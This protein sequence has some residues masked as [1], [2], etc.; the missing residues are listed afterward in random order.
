MPVPKEHAAD[1]GLRLVAGE[2]THLERLRLALDHAPDMLFVI[3]HAEMRF[4]DVNQ[5]ACDLLGYTRSELLA[6]SPQDILPHTRAELEQAYAALIGDPSRSSGLTSHYRCKDGSRV[7]FESKR[8]A[9]RGADGRWLIVVASRDIRPMLAAT[10]ALRESE[11]ALRRGQAMARLAHAVTD[12]DGALLRASDNLAHLLGMDPQ[13]L[14]RTGREWYG[15]VHPDDH[16][17]F[18]EAAITAARSAAHAEIKYRL[19]CGDGTWMHVRHLIEPLEPLAADGGRQWFNTL[20]DITEQVRAEERI[21]RLTRVY[22]VLSG[23]NGLIVR[24]TSRDELFEAACRVAVE[25]GGF[26]MAWIGLVDRDAGLVRPMA[27]A[28][29]VGD[30]FATAPLAILE[31][32]PGGYGLAG[33]AV[34]ERK[35]IVSNDV[36]GDSQ[37]LMKA[38]LAARGID[39]VAIV[40]LIRGEE[41]VGILAL[42][43]AEI[44]FFDEEELRL[45]VELA[46]DIAFGLEHIEKSEKLDY[47]AYYDV[48][49]GLAN[50]TLFLER[51]E[52]QVAAARSSYRKLAIFLMDIERFKPIN[53]ALGRQAGDAL[54]TQ[55][56]ERMRQTGVDPARFGKPAA[57]QFAVLGL[58]VKSE[59]ALARMVESRL[60]ELF[61]RPFRI[62]GQELRVSV[63]VGIAV[64]PNDGGD[65]ETLF[66]NAEAALKKAKA[67]GERYLFHTAELTGQVAERLSLE[68]KLRQALEREEFVLHYQPKIDLETRRIAGVEAL[69]RWQSPELGLVAPGR[70]I[71]VLEETG[72]IQPVGHWALL[73]ASSDYRAWV[74]QGL[75]AP[76]IAVNVSPLQLRQ[77]DFVQRIDEATA[78]NGRRAGIDLEITESLMMANVADNID[79]LNAVRRLGINIAIDD[80][81]TGYSSL[82]YLA[83]L[84]VQSLKIDRSFI[85][86]MHFDSSAMTLVSTIISLAHSMRLKVIAEGVETED[87]AKYLRLLRCDEMQGYLISRPL[88]PAAL[89]DFL[90]RDATGEAGASPSG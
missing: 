12:Q 21:A 20:Q 79:K 49:T 53:D 70:F 6:K 27:S 19:R 54:L 2:R 48:L 16:A 90:R 68:N 24:A 84:P 40:P 82:G 59:E 30:F 38:E 72:L 11:A 15:L 61:E 71:P 87:Q 35:P 69:I 25:Q 66:R 75:S 8:R 17:H 23:I 67:G 80:F 86:T 44:G 5:T 18:R 1:A 88:A 58:D 51:T 55:I 81:G 41:V 22:A 9:V 4:V 39:S 65:A 62:A 77:R 28:G 45:L 60:K 89:V 3:D 33:R 63:R 43:A 26:C 57:D 42:Y 10:E 13:R 50:R 46:G 31:T 36:H 52:Q 29:A 32:R 7:P 78:G 37:R 76:R 14:P 73:R 85:E 83:R 74:S 56:A 64:F 47:L 34:R